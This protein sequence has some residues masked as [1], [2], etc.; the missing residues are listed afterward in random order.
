MIYFNNNILSSITLFECMK[1]YKVFK[2]IFSS[3]ACVYNSNEP[4]PWN[5]KT[6]TGHTT[7]PYGTS[8]YIIE[9]ILMDLSKSDKRWKIG[10]ARYF[11]PI[12]NH[13]SGLFGEDP[14]GIPNNLIPYIIKVIR[15]ELSYLNIYG[16][17]YPT[18][19]GTGIRD[20]IHVEDLVEG[21]VKLL[22]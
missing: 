11:N 14:K 6:K 15:K 21:H 2:I 18:K 16:D 1:K 12:S 17:N 10:I 13:S 4:L 9:R 7:N 3:S 22:K 19:D 8:K 20:Y 5:E